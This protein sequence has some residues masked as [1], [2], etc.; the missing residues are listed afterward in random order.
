[1]TYFYQRI[2]PTVSRPI[3]RIVVKSHDKYAIYHTLIDSGAD[4]CIF[5]IELAKLL[6]I[7]LTKKHTNIKGVGKDK[8]KGYWGEVE[9]IL[10]EYHYQAK[11]IFAEISDFDH[12]ILGQQGFFDNFDVKLSHQKQIIE[13]EPVK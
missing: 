10:N 3:I 5:D 4:Y 9:I 12:G 7:K 6:G 2:N 13:I 8:I 1:M 11:V